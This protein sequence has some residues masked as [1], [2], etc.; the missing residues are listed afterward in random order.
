M[1]RSITGRSTAVELVDQRC[2]RSRSD[3]GLKWPRSL[4]ILRSQ[5]SRERF[6][7]CGFNF[8]GSPLNV[9]HFPGRYSSLFCFLHHHRTIENLQRYH[10]QRFCQPTKLLA[11]L[12][13]NSLAHKVDSDWQFNSQLEMIAH[14]CARNLEMK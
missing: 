14:V 12:L 10:F 11:Q 13:G 8:R 9:M 4:L 3:R 6:L 2:S 1:L 7:F 5:V